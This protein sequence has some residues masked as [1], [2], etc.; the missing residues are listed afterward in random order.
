[1]LSFRTRESFLVFQDR[2][3]CRRLG[4]VDPPKNIFGVMMTSV[5]VKTVTAPSDDPC[6]VAVTCGVKVRGSFLSVH[7][8]GSSRRRK[9]STLDS[10]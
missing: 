7:F 1:M 4:N 2:A 8:R 9:K 10:Q 5:S 3:G 6:H